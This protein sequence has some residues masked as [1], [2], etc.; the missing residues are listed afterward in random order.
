MLVVII[1]VVMNNLFSIASDG[2]RIVIFLKLLVLGVINLI[3]SAISIPVIRKQ[4]VFYF[5][6]IVNGQGWIRNDIER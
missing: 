4:F 6:S 5:S 1:G 3:F 2:S